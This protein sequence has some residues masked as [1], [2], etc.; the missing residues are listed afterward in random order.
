MLPLVIGYLP[1]DNGMRHLLRG[2]RGLRSLLVRAHV[3]VL[4][5]RGAAAGRSGRVPLV[6]SH[7]QGCDPHI[8]SLAGRSTEDSPQ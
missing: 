8:Q 3:H 2:G 1:R 6:Q 5:V 4:P 7:H